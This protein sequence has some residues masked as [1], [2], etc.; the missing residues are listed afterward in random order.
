MTTCESTIITK[1]KSLENI[2]NA[3]K[4][5]AQYWIHKI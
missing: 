5:G 1:I 3:L 4:E 2:I